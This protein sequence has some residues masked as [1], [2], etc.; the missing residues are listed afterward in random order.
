MECLTEVNSFVGTK[1][2]IDV[3]MTGVHLSSGRLGDMLSHRCSL[4]P[5]L[6]EGP[7]TC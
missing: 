2:E 1:M 3:S 4:A 5:A 6:P 7:C